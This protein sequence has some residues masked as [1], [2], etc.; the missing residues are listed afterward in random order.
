MMDPTINDNKRVIIFDTT[1]RDGEQS[2]GASLKVDEKV[3]VA[4]QLARLG[5]D[6][7]EAG[8]AV[9]S[10]GDFE[11]VRRIALEVE[12]PIICS[13]ARA[14]PRDVDAAGKALAGARRTRIHVFISTSEI[15]LRYQFRKTRAE[16]LEMARETVRRA[17]GYTDDVEFSPMD[18][19]RTEPSY[20]YEV[21]H[22][23]IEAGATTV[24]IPD[25]V[26]YATP[27]EIITLMKGIFAHVPN[28]HNAIV[29]THCHDDLGMATANSL[30]AVHCGARQIECT[31]NG[32]GE[33][34]GNA[35]LEEVVMALNTRRN[36]FG[37]Y[38]GI[39][40]TQIMP[41]SRMVSHLMNMP[42]QP[43]KAIV[44]ANAF[45]H[46]SGIHQDGVLKERSTYEIIDA[47]A[48][49]LDDSTLVLGKH[50]GRHA[51]RER[52]TRLGYTLDAEALNRAFARFKEVADTKK[53]VGDTDLELI[54]A[55][56][57]THRLMSDSV[58]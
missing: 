11:A 41:T 31:I 29:S 45:A 52:L 6:V 5:V 50:S 9:S 15:H 58:A 44:G 46:E 40:T 48:V 4:H 22:A 38:T 49:G 7:I 21:L 25:T 34:A 20:L 39:D 37:L 1:L 13:L 47:R 33:R 51:F 27:D 55:E 32:I 43:N 12:G 2:P 42:V 17:R 53:E 18:A 16:A 24:N 28:I 54:V 57:W 26:G 35:A 19:T 23:A 56:M 30:A 36:F 8:F 14:L 3:Q 10:P